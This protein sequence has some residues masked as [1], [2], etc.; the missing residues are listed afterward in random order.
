[1]NLITKILCFLGVMDGCFL[2]AAPQ[3]WFSFWVPVL[4]KIR[5]S[6]KCAIAFG[7]FEVGAS[8]WLLC[9]LMRGR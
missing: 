9:K 8:L 2:M 1:M 5:K 3:Q 4:E 7:A 6:R